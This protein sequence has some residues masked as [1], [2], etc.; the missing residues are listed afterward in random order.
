M[1]NAR[2]HHLDWLR[3]IAFGLLVLFHTGM[4]FVPWGYHI[5]A[6][7]TS[8]ALEF[9]MAWMHAWRMPLL[10]VISGMG[11]A[12]ALGRRSSGIFLKERARRL[13]IP[14]VFGM[15]VVVPSQIYIERIDQFES[16]WAFYPT[17]FELVPYPL[18]G[19]L[20]W[21]HLWF[22]LYL[23]ALS[24]M[25]LPL[26]LRIRR[27][28]KSKDWLAHRILGRGGFAW[29]FLPLFTLH[30]LTMPFFPRFTH[31]LIDDWGRL[32]HYGTFFFAGY[33]LIVIPQLLDRVRDTRHRSLLYAVIALV[34]FFAARMWPAI[35]PASWGD[36]RP[37]LL[38]YDIMYWVPTSVVGWYTCLAILGYGRVLLERPSSTLRYLNNAVYPFYIWHQTVLLIVGA[39]V[40]E[41]IPGIALPFALAAGAT[42]V[43]TLA[44][45]H[46][47]IRPY[48]IMRFL[49]GAKPS[50]AQAADAG[51]H[52][53]PARP[54]ATRS[55]RSPF[56][57]SSES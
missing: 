26:L 33:V 23:F 39:W 31:T 28:Q 9:V 35:V 36:R 16:F 55:E 1:Q 53:I 13:L 50:A 3:I 2:Y 43:L 46:F 17:V 45:Y 20:S 34:P 11:T 24:A 18:G 41:R 56:V 54:E 40:I 5:Q 8:K 51:H 38:G 29:F 25:L 30:L 22:V 12:F 27:N 32:A 14:L 48:R 52:R 47:A 6:R 4:I 44:I 49:H 57:M 42:Y 15:F 10:F 19:S 7:N 21:H 37:A